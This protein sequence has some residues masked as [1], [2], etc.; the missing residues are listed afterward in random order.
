[1]QG[2]GRAADWVMFDSLDSLT[3]SMRSINVDEERISKM[4]NDLATRN[5]FTLSDVYLTDQDIAKLGLFV[6]GKRRFA[7][8]SAVEGLKVDS[9]GV[10]RMERTQGLPSEV[11]RAETIE[12]FAQL[13][14][15]A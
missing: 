1:M 13:R 3:V 15:R 4:Q 5:T 6:L 10:E 11:R 9:D 2:P 14:N 8:I 7:A 12:A